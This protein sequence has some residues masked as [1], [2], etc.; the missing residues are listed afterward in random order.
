MKWVLILV[1]FQT[2]WQGGSE[3]HIVFETREDCKIALAEF[4]PERD[5]FKLCVPQDQ[6]F[7]HYPSLSPA[8]LK[9]QRK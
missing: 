6:E 4:S 5:H 3:R 9:D 2:A 7:W 1:L 8:A